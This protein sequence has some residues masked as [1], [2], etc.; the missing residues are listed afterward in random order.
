MSQEQP[1]KEMTLQ[2]IVNEFQRLTNQGMTFADAI[3]D[4]ALKKAQL[5]MMVANQLA[6]TK[7][8]DKTQRQSKKKVSKI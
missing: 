6:N 7:S 3:K 4:N 5:L 8:N 2:D 1:K